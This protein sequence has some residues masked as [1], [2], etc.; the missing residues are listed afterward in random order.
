[1]PMSAAAMEGIQVNGHHW[2]RQI[3]LGYEPKK[4]GALN[5]AAMA[6]ETIDD[7]EVEAIA[8]RIASN[9]RSFAKMHPQFE[10]LEQ[11]AENLEMVADC[12]LEEVNAVMSDLYDAF[13]FNRIL[14]VSPRLSP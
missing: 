5:N 7:K 6:G 9:V 14:V 2:Q 3:R 10:H 11:E 12:G 13:D 4:L 1:M 8:E